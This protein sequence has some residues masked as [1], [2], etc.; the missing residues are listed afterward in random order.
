MAKSA[1]PQTV[2]EIRRLA[3]DRTRVHTTRQATLG[4]LAQQ[5]TV[6]DVCRQDH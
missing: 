1:N 6:D 3:V 5:L 4:M 2:Q